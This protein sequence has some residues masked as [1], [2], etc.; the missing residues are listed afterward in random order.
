MQTGEQGL[1][2]STGT[3]SGQA[4]RAKG[5]RF[6][7]R[8]ITAPTLMNPPGHL[9]KHMTRDEYRDHLANGID[10]LFVYQGDTTDAD[11]GYSAGVR[12]AQRVKAAWTYLGAP[13]TPTFF[14]N[15]R[16]T[17]P[18]PAAWQAYLDGAA[19]VL[20]REYVGAYGFGNAMDAARGHASYFWQAGRESDV[21]SFVHV[22]QWN[23]GSVVVGGRTC[24]INKARL[25]IT[26]R[27]EEDDMTPDQSNR[28]NDVWT[29]MGRLLDEFYASAKAYDGKTIPERLAAVE[30]R[31]NASGTVEVDYVKLAQALIAELKGE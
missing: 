7:I 24:D 28:L 27:G 14:T 5:Y 1:D 10:V 4:I 2:Y 23:N 13:P 19:S 21:R 30:D 20:G 6:V 12:N 26:S 17:L 31:V 9:A 16:T 11:G 18:N 8:Y 22:Y 3:I 25:T 15:D 29:G